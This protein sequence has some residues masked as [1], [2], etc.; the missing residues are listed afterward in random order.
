MRRPTFSVW[1]PSVFGSV[2]SNVG[3]VPFGSLGSARR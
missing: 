3:R 1:Y 2:M